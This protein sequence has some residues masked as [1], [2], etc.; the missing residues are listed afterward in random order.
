MRDCPKI[1][2]ALA[3]ELLDISVRLT[4][5]GIQYDNGEEPTFGLDLVYM[6]GKIQG[7]IQP[8]IDRK[9]GGDKS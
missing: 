8:Y 7:W 4:N 5:I 1:P 3:K 2:D 9:R 6:G